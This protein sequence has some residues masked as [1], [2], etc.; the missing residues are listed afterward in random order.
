MTMSEYLDSIEGTEQE[1]QM[2]QAIEDLREDLTVAAK[3]PFV[4]KTIVALLAFADLETIERFKQTI[5]YDNIK[6]WNIY[7]GD[8]EKG[9]FSI[10]PGDKQ[11][12]KIATAALIIFGVLFLM[13]LWKRVKK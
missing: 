12:K 13:W 9:H 11:L 4:G 6:D 1:Q 3:I 10:Y 5:H 8:M 7:V 2:V